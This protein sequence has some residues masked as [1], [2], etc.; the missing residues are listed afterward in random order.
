MRSAA[1]AARI[2]MRHVTAVARKPIADQPMRA[3][4]MAPPWRAPFATSVRNAATQQA[5]Y[6]R[7]VIWTLGVPTRFRHVLSRET[8]R[9]V[10]RKI[11]SYEVGGCYAAHVQ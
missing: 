6:H 10:R 1:D 7:R 11:H 4:H 3:V 2:N 5:S 9:R 8:V